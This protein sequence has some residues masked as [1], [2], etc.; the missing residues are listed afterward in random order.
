MFICLNICLKRQCYRQSLVVGT[1]M[2]MGAH[3]WDGGLLGD[4][5]LLGDGFCHGDG[6]CR[7]NGACCRDACLGDEELSSKL[8]EKLRQEAA[9][10]RPAWAIW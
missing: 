1:I 3:H 2:G 5:H 6:G 9:D 4:G 8:L 7:G 10:S